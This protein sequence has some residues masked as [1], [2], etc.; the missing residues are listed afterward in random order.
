MKKKNLFMALAALFVLAFASCN[1]EPEITG[2]GID[3]G[4]NDKQPTEGIFSWEFSTSFG[5]FT[6]QDVLGDESWMID[7]ETAKMTGYINAT[8]NQVG[9]CYR[10]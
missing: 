2:P 9:E 3:D 7:Y 1:N 8:R 10:C 5:E 4:G 6:T